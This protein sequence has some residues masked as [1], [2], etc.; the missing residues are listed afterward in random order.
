ML[1]KSNPQDKIWSRIKR[2]QS[3]PFHFPLLDWG[4]RKTE[5]I[6][7]K[8]L[9]EQSLIDYKDTV[10]TAFKE[11]SNAL[12]AKNSFLKQ[13][14]IA[15]SNLNIGFEALNHKRRLFDSGVSNR[16]EFLEAENEQIMIE[17]AYLIAVK[18]TLINDINLFKALGGQ[19]V[20]GD[21][22]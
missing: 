10:D 21:S 9:K 8:I 22:E 13:E 4:E 17:K 20:S 12:V 3:K 18:N 14:M 2:F 5:V 15:E 6:V 1:I 11:V 7:A 16:I 19:W